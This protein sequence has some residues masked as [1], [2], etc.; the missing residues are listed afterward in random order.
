MIFFLLSQIWANTTACLS[1]EEKVPIDAWEGMGYA[2]EQQGFYLCAPPCSGKLPPETCCFTPVTSLIAGC[3][4]LLEPSHHNLH[5]SASPVECRHRKYESE[6]GG[7][8]SNAERCKW[9]TRPWRCII[10]LLDHIMS[11]TKVNYWGS[12]DHVIDPPLTRL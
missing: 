12:L 6:K 3:V 9:D 4:C 8:F 2:S 1:L 7:I 10:V 5:P 11:L